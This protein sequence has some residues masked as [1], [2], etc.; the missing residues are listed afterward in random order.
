[1]NEKS[2]DLRELA[3]VLKKRYRL[4]LGVFAAAVAITALVSI[5]MA[6]TFEA[7][8]TLR[9]K[10]PKGLGSSLL[11][12]LP[13]GS[14]AGTKQQMA[15]Y[16]E[17]IK[18]HTVV[19]T[20]IDNT[21]GE[22]KELPAYEDMLKRINTVPVK[23]TEI[24]KI[25]VRAKSPAE[26]RQL[27]DLLVEAFVGRMTGLV[28]A[29]QTTVREFIG[30]RLQEARQELDNAEA[31]LEQYKRDQKIVA[32]EQETKSIVDRMS[33]VNKLAAD[34]AVGLASAQARLHSLQQQLDRQNPGFIADSPLIQQYKGK[35][36]E[37]EI[38]LVKLR[39]NYTDAHPQVLAVRAAIAETKTNLNDECARVIN[40]EAPSMN[41]VHQSLLQARLQTEA[42]VAAIAAQRGAISGII[43]EGE[44]ELV[45]RPAKEQGLAKLVRNAV[46][47]QEVFSLL[48]KRYEEARISE[49]MQPTDVQVI[50]TAVASDK[51]VKPRL[52][53]NLVIA[54]L[55]GLLLGAG[56]AVFQEYINRTVRTAEDVKHY[57]DLPV[58]GSI[59]AYEDIRKLV[60]ADGR[61]G[62]LKARLGL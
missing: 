40:A 33:A 15:T 41:P 13:L 49:I 36:A 17:I 16:A 51:P 6:P 20:V 54:A 34:N 3:K 18:S 27:A 29:E 22:Y 45:S 5:L 23:D 35:L 30:E 48:A 47:A 37:L 2:I 31:A 1:M 32:P 43:T 46:I 21:A 52:T 7:E 11:I 61:W 38:E 19:Q 10:Q 12:D 58:L 24:L 25:Y 53:L 44:R 9:I 56:L 42:E 14:P 50:D 8:T 4:I 59:P 39:Q 28:R 55:L 26:A 57:L 62:K 60:A